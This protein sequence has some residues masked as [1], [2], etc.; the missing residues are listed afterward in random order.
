MRLK[1]I[2]Y[3]V[4]LIRVKYDGGMDKF[5]EDGGCISYIPDPV[6]RL[7]V[8]H[9][10]LP[11]SL[12]EE[13]EKVMPDGFEYIR[14]VAYPI[15]ED[16]D[17]ARS[18]AEYL[19]NNF[20]GSTLRGTSLSVNGACS[21][22]V[23]STLDAESREAV[24]LEG[25]LADKLGLCY[26]LYKNEVYHRVDDL[27]SRR[28]A[29]IESQKMERPNRETVISDDDILNVQIALGQAETVEDFLNSI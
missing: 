5:E 14:D 9:P 29:Q 15:Q 3:I 8:K 19:V 22:L 1:Q 26:V 20:T 25:W 12:L 13:C 6:D 27:N 21:I 2:E 16:L 7:I 23:F 10:D 18:I 11:K 28:D 17:L 4:S 24:K